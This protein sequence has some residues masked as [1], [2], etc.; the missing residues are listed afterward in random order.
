MTSNEI[1]EEL[2]KALSKVDIIERAARVFLVF[3]H[4]LKSM[5]KDENF[6][7][8]P[9]ALFKQLYYKW[10]LVCDE[11]IKDGFD[12]PKDLFIIFVR[13]FSEEEKTIKKMGWDKIKLPNH[14]LVKALYEVKEAQTYGTDMHNNRA[15]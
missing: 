4:T 5:I 7:Q 10:N 13:I 3:S 2:R 1:K 9:Q 15:D 14:D 11:L 12:I 8:N 6:M